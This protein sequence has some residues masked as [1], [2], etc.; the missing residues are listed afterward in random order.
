MLTTDRIAQFLV[1]RALIPSSWIIDGSLRI[2]GAAGR[3]RTFKITGPGGA[4]LFLKQNEG[5]A[6]DVS[7]PL[8]SEALFNRYCR[9]EP[10]LARL[11]DFLPGLVD[12]DL[13]QGVVVFDGIADVTGWATLLESRGPQDLAP[14][15][16]WATGFAFGTLH[17]LSRQV[18]QGG[19]GPDW[20]PRQVPW[21][22]RAHRPGVQLLADLNPAALEVLR[23]LQADATFRDR[24][25]PLHRHWRPEVIIHG[26]V[27]FDNILVRVTQAGDRGE[28][29][30]WIVDW[31]LVQIGD[32]AWD[33]AGAL[34]DL[35]A[36]W[37][38]SMPLS[39]DVSVEEVIVRAGIP[40]AALR[41][42]LRELWSGYR[43]GAGVG[44][45]EAE[46]L[47]S[48][49]VAF[50]AARLVQSAFEG[51]ITSGHLPVRSVLLLQLAANVLAEPERARI[52][53][54][55]LSMSVPR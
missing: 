35:L 19:E 7:S 36:Y 52:E 38:A 28:V 22:M 51:A 2:T 17:R 39:S 6:L 40:L 11:A 55:G 15:A 23:I 18:L 30:L 31:E 54:Y 53:L 26:D 16:A 25:D 48:R 4:C 47:L 24:L 45:V 9:G 27:R 5:T 43:E 3:N 42:T 32:P 34:Q 10:S 46:A 37:V 44:P 49:A 14:R 29:E 8:H 41:P 50:S 20:L 21:A 12:V 1:D 33:L 13:D